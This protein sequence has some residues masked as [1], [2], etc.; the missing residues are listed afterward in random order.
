MLFAYYLTLSGFLG[1][2]W[3]R[4]AEPCTLFYFIFED[5]LKCF[6]Y[7]DNGE[8]RLIYRV[9]VGVPEGDRALGRSRRRWED[10]FKMDFYEVE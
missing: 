9:L 3:S 7:A 4:T 8:M 6:A 2:I 10:I 5:Q 1:D